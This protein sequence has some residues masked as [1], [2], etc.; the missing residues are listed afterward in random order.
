MTDNKYKCLIDA[1]ANSGLALPPIKAGAEVEDL[2]RPDPTWDDFAHFSYEGVDGQRKSIGAFH[3]SKE[4]AAGGAEPPRGVN[5]DSSLYVLKSSLDDQPGESH[6]DRD[7]GTEVSA[8]QNPLPG[9]V[10]DTIDK[11]FR[12]RDPKIS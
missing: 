6:V 4:T 2:T 8:R 7:T 11:V 1:L 3:Y 5:H 9:T 10:N 12:C